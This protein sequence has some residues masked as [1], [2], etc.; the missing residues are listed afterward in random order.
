M[1]TFRITAVI[2]ILLQP[3]RAIIAA[4]G[5]ISLYY[6]CATVIQQNIDLQTDKIVAREVSPDGSWVALVDHR[7]KIEDVFFNLSIIDIVWLV[8]VSEEKAFPRNVP[9]WYD[10]NLIMIRHSYTD[11]IEDRLLIC[12]LS[13]NNLE[14]KYPEITTDTYITLSPQA[15]EGVHVTFSNK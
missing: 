14:V 7:F 3:I 11:R 2:S 12:W 6:I 9:P 1:R 4:L 5:A 8:K 13:D 10:K 15:D